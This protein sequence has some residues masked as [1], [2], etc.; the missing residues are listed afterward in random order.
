[1][2]D[3]KLKYC[4]Q[5]RAKQCRARHPASF[6]YAATSQA[7]FYRIASITWAAAKRSRPPDIKRGS[8]VLPPTTR[9]I[10]REKKRPPTVF[11]IEGQK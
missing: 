3:A 11:T 7:G 5:R 2:L 4:Y 1:M 6:H 10:R 9:R 8:T